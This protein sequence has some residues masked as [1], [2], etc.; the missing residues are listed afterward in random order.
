[1]AFHR[2]NK[3]SVE[4]G[5]KQGLENAPESNMRRDNEQSDTIEGRK[6]TEITNKKENEQAI[7]E[8]PNKPKLDPEI[9]TQLRPANYGQP[10]CQCKMCK[11]NRINGNKGIINHGEWKPLGILADN[12]SNRV[13]LPGDVDCKGLEV[14]DV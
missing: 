14:I 4:L 6:R 7:V 8:I 3:D 9:K 13:A 10:D 11:A 1:M 5:Q 12:E 2:K